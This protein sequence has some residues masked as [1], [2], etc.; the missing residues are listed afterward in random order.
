MD[1]VQPCMFKAIGFIPSPVKQ[2]QNAKFLIMK[3]IL[4]LFIILS[5]NRYSSQQIYKQIAELDQYKTIQGSI[6][7]F[8]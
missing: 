7:W 4:N 2:L 5:F 1:I 8:S 3:F 6:K